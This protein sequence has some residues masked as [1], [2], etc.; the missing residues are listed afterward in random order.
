MRRMTDMGSRISKRPT[1]LGGALLS[2]LAALVAVLSWQIVTLLNAITPAAAAPVFCGPT[3]LHTMSEPPESRLTRDYALIKVLLYDPDDHLSH[4]RQLYEGSLRPG[5]SSQRQAWPRKSSEPSR[6]F[7]GAISTDPGFGSLQ[8]EADR[9]DRSYGTNLIALIDA[10]LV[11]RDRA[12]LEAAFYDMFTLLVQEL[13]SSIQQRLG[14]PINAARIM[15][16]VRRYYAV[17]LEAHLSLRSPVSSREASTALLAMARA[18]EDYRTGAAASS[19][20]W[21]DRERR[22]FIRSIALA[23]E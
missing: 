9:L 21:F 13:L 8:H 17:G 23:G 20:K 16:H 10:G 7:K 14:D 18:L 11:A 1:I 3:L 15:A 6:L 5:K 19:T 4:V 2:A 12:A 22:A